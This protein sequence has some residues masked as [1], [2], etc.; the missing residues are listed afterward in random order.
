MLRRTGDSREFAAACMAAVMIAGLAYVGVL[1]LNDGRQPATHSE[2]TG[3]IRLA[4]PR[5]DTPPEPPKPKKLE[6]T[7]PPEKL[8]KTVSQRS[9]T[10]ANKPQMSV[11]L[12]SFS[13]DLHPGLGG[14]I[15]IPDMDLGG[16][17]FSM[18]EVDE[19]PH[20]L[21]SVP[22]EYPYTAQ[23]SRIE[24]EVVVR[25]LVTSQGEPTNV[26]IHSTNPP[27]V[28]DKAALAAAKR[29]KFQPG[30]YQGRAVDT[31]VLLPFTFELTR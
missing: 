31:W 6:E 10:Q 5:A 25:M 13:A 23:R 17:G 22:P 9:K 3:A 29:W 4:V 27:G 24:G 1:L 12:P 11:S 8:P 2:I 7:K 16:V 26:T 14:G 21:R 18:D 15:A 30:R 20:P 28:F 19:V